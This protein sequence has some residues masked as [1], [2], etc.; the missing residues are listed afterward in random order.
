M[1][2][3]RCARCRRHDL[4][5]AAGRQELPHRE[6]TA[7]F[8]LD[9]PRANSEREWAPSQAVANQRCRLRSLSPLLAGAPPPATIT[10]ENLAVAFFPGLLCALT[11]PQRKESVQSLVGCFPSSDAASDDRRPG[12]LF[13]SPPR[14]PPHSAPRLLS[15]HSTSKQSRDRPVVSSK[16]KKKKH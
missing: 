12:Q 6:R 14:P 11:Q 16:K 9:A 4:R 3:W 2:R 5:R 13:P 7:I 1:L 8:N 10:Q 15:L